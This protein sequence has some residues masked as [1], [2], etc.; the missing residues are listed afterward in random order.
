MY[1]YYLIR[2]T[3]LTNIVNSIRSKIGKIVQIDD[4]NMASEIDGMSSNDGTDLI[5]LTER[6][7]TGFE[8]PSGLTSIENQ[9]FYNCSGITISS[10]PSGITK[11]GDNALRSCTGITI[12]SIPTNVTINYNYIG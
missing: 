11:I 3:I 10:L 5:P 6:P 4:A 7:I 9:T 2:G 8:L 1:E 12:S